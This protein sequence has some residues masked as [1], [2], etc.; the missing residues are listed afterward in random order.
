MKDTKK[1]EIKDSVIRK[2]SRALETNLYRSAENQKYLMEIN[3]QK[4]Y[5][6]LI[7][8][9]CFFVLVF[10]EV[11]IALFVNDEWIRPYVG[12][13]LVVIA[14]YTFVRIFIPHRCVALPMIILFFACLVEAL[15]YINIVDKIGLG[16]V[17]FFRVLIGTVG[18]PKDIICYAVGCILLIIYEMIRVRI[19][20][21]R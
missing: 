8:G 15:Q 10:A 17:K 5:S 12:D 4:D 19:D 14:I 18:D 1:Y 9:I 2:K 3:E 20:K 7:Y 6:R 16:D 21:N 13:V 11:M